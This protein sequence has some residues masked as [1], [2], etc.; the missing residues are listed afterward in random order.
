MAMRTMRTLYDLG[1]AFNGVMDM[2]LDETMDLKV[3]EECLQT[4]E[5]DIAVKRENGIGLI[6]S[7][8]NL[9]DGMK[10]EAKRL[11]ERQRVIDNRISS[12]K[13]WYA[14]NLDAMGKD[15][16]VTDRGTMRVQ[17]N[18]PAYPR[19][20][21]NMEKIPETYFD[22]VPQHLELN[23]DRV[24]EALKAGIDVPGA[25]RTQTRGLRIQ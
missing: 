9:R 5:A 17:N 1:D 20:L 3:L 24:K 16:V 14:K 18:P 12:I 7:L 10:A 21:W 25:F 19:E 22:I 6:R 13:T 2:A 23:M 8:E 11:T 4:I 15:K